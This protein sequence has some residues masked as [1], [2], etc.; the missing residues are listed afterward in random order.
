VKV[1]I[2]LVTVDGQVITGR[3]FYHTCRDEPLSPPQPPEL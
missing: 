3:R 1:D 2:R